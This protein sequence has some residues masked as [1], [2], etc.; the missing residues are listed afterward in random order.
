MTPSQC[1][2]SDHVDHP[3]A[4]AQYPL[5]CEH[6]F[7]NGPKRV[8]RIQLAGCCLFKEV[9]RPQALKAL[10]TVVSFPRFY[11]LCLGMWVGGQWR[12][13]YGNDMGILLYLPGIYQQHAISYVAIIYYYC[14]AT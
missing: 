7:A 13:R 2:I 5:L 11:K 6:N 9:G 10:Q 12:K 14:I 1:A 8:A 3:V 4:V